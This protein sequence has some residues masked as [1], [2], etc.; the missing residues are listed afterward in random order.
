MLKRSALAALVL[1]GVAS[2]AHAEVQTKLQPQS[3]PTGT[4]GGM[5]NTFNQ[6]TLMRQ[7]MN[8]DAQS[9]VTPEQLRRAKQAAALI[10][11]N[12]CEDAYNLAYNEQDFRL[13]GNIAV[14]CKA[15]F[16]Q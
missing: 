13:A 4:M 6:Q 10:K 12:R 14:A 16:R 1:V 11:A 8:N 3:N 5:Y 2:G 7:G 15:H 9:N